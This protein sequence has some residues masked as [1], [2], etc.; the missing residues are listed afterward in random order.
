MRQ[1]TFTK[2]AWTI[3]GAAEVHDYYVAEG[4]VEVSPENGKDYSAAICV[5][6]EIAKF[7]ADLGHETPVTF[8]LDQMA[9]RWIFGYQLPNGDLVDL[10]HYTA[11]SFPQWAQRR[12]T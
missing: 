5:P 2:P 10:W 11:N 3:Y 1:P 8:F 6:T 4:K 12:L 7:L 9:K